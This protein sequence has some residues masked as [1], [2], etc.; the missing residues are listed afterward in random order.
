MEID[1]FKLCFCALIL[2]A[3]T[4]SIEKV[5]PWFSLFIIVSMTIWAYGYLFY[6]LFEMFGLR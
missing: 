2:A 3:V 5:K 4:E 1:L 6:K